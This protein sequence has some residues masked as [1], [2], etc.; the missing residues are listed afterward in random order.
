MVGVD[1]APLRRYAATDV[2]LHERSELLHA[3]D[4]VL[5]LA[6]HT[7]VVDDWNS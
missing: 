5:G 1:H 3:L 7:H 2:S 4:L 6:M